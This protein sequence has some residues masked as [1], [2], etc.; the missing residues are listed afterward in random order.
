M[1]TERGRSGCRQQFQ[2][3][4]VMN[5]RP[6]SCPSSDHVTSSASSFR[7]TNSP[8]MLSLSRSS[9]IGGWTCTWLLAADCPSPSLSPSSLAS[10][11]PGFRSQL[12]RMPPGRSTPAASRWSRSPS[13]LP[14]RRRSSRESAPVSKHHRGRCWWRSGLLPNRLGGADPERVGASV[15]D[16]EDHF[17]IDLDQLLLCLAVVATVA[18]SLVGRRRVVTGRANTRAA[19]ADG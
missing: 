8:V 5:S 4:H 3:P 7:I 6:S 10:R 15:F 16:G 11:P 9:A 1:E 17:R 2:F 19:S 18:E 13:H 14:A 12:T